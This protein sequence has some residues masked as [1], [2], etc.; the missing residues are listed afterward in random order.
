LVI[1]TGLFILKSENLE[2]PPVK[3][4]A[5]ELLSG[6]IKQLPNEMNLSTLNE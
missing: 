5:L 6:I 2:D 1:E 4:L 3:N